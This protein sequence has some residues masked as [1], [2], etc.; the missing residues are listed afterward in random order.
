M[1]KG[2]NFVLT[3][4]V[5]TVG[6]QA[7]CV[8][9]AKVVNWDVAGALN[10]AMVQPVAGAVYRAVDGRVG[11]DPHHPSLPDFLFEVGVGPD[12]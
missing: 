3:A 4:N 7:I 1:A 2:E 6:N 9:V 8:A 12:G 5:F 11:E 10:G